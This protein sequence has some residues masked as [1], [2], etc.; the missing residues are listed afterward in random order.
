M[1]TTII[2]DD[3]LGERLRHEA[4]RRKQSFSAFMADAGRKALA[5]HAEEPPAKG[6]DLITYGK[7]GVRYGVDLNQ[8]GALLAAEDEEAYR[9]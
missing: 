5:D 7:G 3:H 1:R 8:T 2:L 4:R 6:F 9:T